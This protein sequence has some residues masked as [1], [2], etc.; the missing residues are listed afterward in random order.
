MF[1][2]CWVQVSKELEDE[3]IQKIADTNQTNHFRK[4]LNNNGKFMNKGTTVTTASTAAI[5]T[6]N[7]S[8]KNLLQLKK[9][10]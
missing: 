5:A 6:R 1:M 7:N 4:K 8:A 2:L 10:Y 3:S 9:S